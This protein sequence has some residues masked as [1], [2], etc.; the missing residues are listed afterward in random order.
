[1]G[2]PH[3]KGKQGEDIAAMYLEGKG[4]QVRERNVHYRGGEID[5]VAFDPPLREL[6]FVEVKSKSSRAF[7][8]PEEDVRGHK[9]RRLRVSAGLYLGAHCQGQALPYRFDI[10]AVELGAEKARVTHYKNVEMG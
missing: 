9:R 7:G 3:P 10:I 2:K 5:I 1:M 6:V 8:W 4:Y